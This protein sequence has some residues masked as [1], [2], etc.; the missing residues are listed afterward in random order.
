V[1]ISSDNGSYQVQITFNEKPLNA[2]IGLATTSVITADKKENVLTVPVDRVFK[3]GDSY[4]VREVEWIN[5]DQN[6]YS[7]KNIKITKGIE[8]DDKIEVL[9]G[10]NEGD[11]LALE[12]DKLAQY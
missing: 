1:D 8:N 5:K 2:K 12:N 7:L 11:T 6:I 10:L 3:Q 9:T 4:F